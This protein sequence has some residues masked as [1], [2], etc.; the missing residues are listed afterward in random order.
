MREQMPALFTADLQWRNFSARHRIT[1]RGQ[2][3]AG[4]ADALWLRVPAAARSS[5]P[6]GG[7]EKMRILFGMNGQELGHRHHGINRWVDS[8]GQ[9][10]MAPFRRTQER[11]YPGYRPRRCIT[12]ISLHWRVAPSVIMATVE[13]TE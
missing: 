11:E 1:C 7:Y 4:R 6:V 10:L 2:A 12:R 13:Q 8:A 9:R 5:G 3:V